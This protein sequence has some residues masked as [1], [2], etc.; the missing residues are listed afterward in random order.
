MT[1]RTTPPSSPRA[2]DIAVRTWFLLPPAPPNSKARNFV[3]VSPCDA[4]NLD[5]SG[6]P[7]PL[8][9]QSP[10]EAPNGA[11]R[12]G[13]IFLFCSPGTR[14]WLEGMVAVLNPCKAY[15]RREFIGFHFAARTKTIASTL[16]D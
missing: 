4:T 16:Y 13:E 14:T 9:C 10:D 2:A 12:G 5:D 6:I 3:W 1:A 8:M 15:L 7:Q 11:D